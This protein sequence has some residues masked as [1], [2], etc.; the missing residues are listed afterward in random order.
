M[1]KI[2]TISILFILCFNNIDLLAQENKEDVKVGVVLSGGGA[3]A[4]AHIAL[5][6]A[7]DSAG[8]RVDYIGGT[9]MGAV[10]GSL[11]ASGYTGNQIDS[12][13]RSID[14]TKLVMDE[15]PR[16]SK[17]FFDKENNE[18]YALVLPVNKGKVGLP[19]AL[20]KGQNILNGL[21]KL[22][23]HVD[24]ISDFSKLP[25][26]FVCIATD[27]E[28]GKAKVLKKGYL[29]KAVQASGAF[30]TLIEPV[31]IDGQLLVDGGVV[32]NFP[33]KEVRNMGANLIIGVQL[34]NELPKRDR[35]DSGIDIINQLVRFQMYSSYDENIEETD[36]LISPDTKAYSVTSF[37]EYE[38]IYDIGKEVAQQYYQQFV[39]IA[40]KQT[41]VRE[42]HTLK[43]KSKTVF[44]DDVVIRGNVDYTRKYIR[45]KINLKEGKEV[46]RKKIYKGIDNLFATGNFSRI[47]YR[48]I[49]NAE[50]H[51]TLNLKVKQNEVSTFLKFGVHYDDLYKAAGLVNITSQHL[52]SKNDII[53][54]DL[55][56]GDNPRYNFR[57]YIDNVSTFSFGIN[58]RYYRFNADIEFLHDPNINDIDLKYRD[59]TNQLFVE[60]VFGDFFKI[61]GGLEHKNISAFSN[62]LNSVIPQTI[63]EGDRSYFDHSNY[64]NLIGFVKIDNYDKAY[65][66]KKGFYLDGNL[67][68]Y[69]YS[70]N[71]DYNFNQF[72]QIQGKVGLAY[73]FFDS[74]T[75]Q[76]LSEAG[77]N[78]GENGVNMLDFHLGG[79]GENYINTFV[80]FYGYQFS[81]FT[82]D[83]YLLSTLKTRVEIF[84]KNY[85]LGRVDAAR[86]GNDFINGG[87]LFAD[88]KL[89]YGG[90][91][92]IESIIGPLEINYA[93][94][95]D[96]KE[97]Y[98]YFVVGFW[99]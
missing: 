41:I 43:K 61:G 2:V 70:D 50:N 15:V 20:S 58:S 28:T 46:D 3:K 91:Y 47:D 53:S 85:L 7:I 84:K 67:R 30:P 13:I 60:N 68:W 64:I 86:L 56:I 51:T 9:S 94:S 45:S 63:R 32:D 87:D 23:E 4:F 33:V 80:P 54:L 73:T 59:F 57:Y 39:E 40:K 71:T 78:V 31:E 10:I 89:G 21:N 22:L 75:F 88:T 5:L 92:G 35:L 29:P 19:R 98:W 55:I 24:S 97:N 66:P 27:L 72:S 99:F 83:G 77:L 37:N 17:S 11:Y 25:I 49:E 90:G 74:L 79:F 14:F 96:V 12:I 69:M 16:K 38:P 8:V 93:Y 81:S 76:F 1:K 52:I 82:T 36:L 44:L 6:Q 34:G 62:S 95:P 65:Y 18:K 42:K 48:F 26:P